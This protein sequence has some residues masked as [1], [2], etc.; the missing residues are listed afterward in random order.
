MVRTPGR[1]VS[2]MLL[3]V[4]HRAGAPAIAGSLGLTALLLAAPLAEV[5]A[6]PSLPG[7][8]TA[9]ASTPAPAPLGA[10]AN[11]TPS[12]TEIM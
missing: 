11:P 10:L 4:R 12:G 3:G 2:A 1:G 5:Y 9:P 8:P 6:V 7:G